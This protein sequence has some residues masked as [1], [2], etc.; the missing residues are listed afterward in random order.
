L[1]SAPLRKRSQGPAPR[2]ELRR[3]LGELDLRAKKGLG[4]H[5]LVDKGALKHILSAAEL[6][7]S[8]IVVEVGAGLGV[9]TRELAERVRWVVAI[10]IDSKL[11]SA[12]SQRLSSFS[13]ITLINVDVLQTEP[14]TLLSQIPGEISS[15]GLPPYKMVANLP[16]YIASAV[17]RHFLEASH[18]PSRMVVTVQKEVA[19]NMVAQPGRMGLLSVGI[20]FYGKPT[21]VHMIPSGSFYPK[22]KVDSAVVAIDVYPR[23]AVEVANV[24]RFFEVVRAGFSA[25]RKQLRNALAHGLGIP[26]PN[27]EE[28]LGQ[29]CINPRRRAE[30]LSLEEWARLYEVV[31]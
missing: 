12:L 3:L 23:S 13:N 20:Q 2:G 27:A 25:P 19:E 14:S 28:L 18:K 31:S 22:P 16:Y 24:E 9:L 10:E 21:I 4:Q 7:S 17:L 5:F 30:A 29:A 8:D 11:V 1:K 26:P 15:K 6:K